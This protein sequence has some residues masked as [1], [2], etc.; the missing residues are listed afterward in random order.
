MKVNRWV[1]KIC[2]IIMLISLG[3]VIFFSVTEY[4][5]EVMYDLGL[6]IFGSAALSW[7][8]GLINFY[9]DRR[10]VKRTVI[11]NILQIQ[12]V[13]K[14]ILSEY[15]KLLKDWDEEDFYREADT[16]SRLIDDNFSYLDTLKMEMGEERRWYI[17]GKELS[18]IYKSFYF[19]KDDIR[20]IG[21]LVKNDKRDK[22]MEL[23]RECR[24]NDE[25]IVCSIKTM[26]EKEYG[27]N[28]ADYNSIGLL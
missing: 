18:E 17:N 28:F 21:I 22:A 12:K 5:D 9:A 14:R 11:S 1:M 10:T 15:C 2:F 3:A 20:T 6:A 16:M 13:A 19:L 27:K 23:Y 8:T 7:V 4:D 24:E 25:K 26:L